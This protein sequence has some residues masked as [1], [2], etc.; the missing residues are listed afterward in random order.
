MTKQAKERIRQLEDE[1][2]RHNRLYYESDSPTI[3]DSQYDALLREL[4]DLEKSYPELANPSSPTRRVGGAAL[5]KFEQASHK[6][7]MLSLDN[8]LE[9][10]QLLDFDERVRQRLNKDDEQ[11]HY[12]AEPKFDG[13]AVSLWYQGGRLVN[14]L[15]RGDGAVGEVITANV[16]TIRD[17]PLE[18]LDFDQSEDGFVE[19]RGEI[20]I[21]KAGFAQLN[22][23]AIAKT[24]Q[25]VPSSQVKFFA[26]PRNAAAGS[27]RQLD[28]KVAATRPLSFFAYGLGFFEN[29]SELERLTKHSDVMQWLSHRG[30]PVNMYSEVK[31]DIH[32][33]VNYF[34]EMSEKRSKL[35]YDID[36]IVFKVNSLALQEEL[37]FVARAPRWAIAAKFPADEQVTQ[38]MAV[39]F[40]VGRTGAL[41]PVAR[42]TPVEVGGVVV[43][44]ATL[45]NRDE[46]I[47]LDLKIHDYVCV[48]RAGDVIPKIAAVVHDQR[49]SNTEEIVFPKQCPECGS[50]I[51]FNDGEAV[52]RCSGVLICPAQG[53]ARLKHFV[54]RKAMDIDGLGERILL[55]LMQ[56]FS[57]QN[58]AD[59]YSLDVSALAALPGY[60]EKSA[61][62]LAGAIERSKSTTLARF[63]Y[64]LGIREVGHTTAK[65]L[66][67]TFGSLA[68]LRAADMETLES[69]DDIGPITA[70]RV[71]TFFANKRNQD[72]VDRLI[73][74]GIS[75]EES[76]SN[77]QDESGSTANQP[78]AGFTV[79]L[80]GSLSSIKRD[81]AK[82]QLEQLGFKVASAVSSKTAL[83]IAGEKAGSK[84]AKA[85]KLKVPVIDEAMLVSLLN[86]E[87]VQAIKDLINSQHLQ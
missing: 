52:A 60:G 18:L 55:L 19:V 1:I 26:N 33:C 41:T 4:Q 80:T 35:A 59:L 75:W 86:E 30:F 6:K 62:N 10:S 64:S 37:G 32:E 47:R 11:I 65:A 46:I 49:P 43:T 25:G 16:S 58:P 79:V 22:E 7:P 78:F 72:L 24:E 87:S 29:I 69:V 51:L 3:S 39:D 27:I 15:T 82:E 45:H 9:V 71:H 2:A 31:K 17:I 21:S 77:H 81:D 74:L 68:S 13:I 83:L 63:I 12:A 34:E 38:L 56:K 48:Q 76:G 53:L 50:T 23:E 44:N 42:L 28:P 40:Q 66:A 84:L 14:A 57:V 8:A 70:A 20:Y 61:A 5:E 54:Q 73:K 36:G 67:K 85:E